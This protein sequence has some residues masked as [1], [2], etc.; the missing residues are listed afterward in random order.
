MTNEWLDPTSEMLQDPRFEAIWQV[1][2][3]WDINV[4]QAYRGYS[5]AT[6]NHVRAIL[7]ALKGCGLCAAGMNSFIDPDTGNSMHARNGVVTICGSHEP[8]VVYRKWPGE[9]P[10]CMSCDCGMTEEQKRTVPLDDYLRIHR[11]LID[12]KYPGTAWDPNR[13]V[14]CGGNHGNLPCPQMTVTCG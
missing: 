7:D 5:G 12:L 9:P 14:V 3:T 10:H 1:I 8:G 6:G 4:P 11:Q 2:K 13:C